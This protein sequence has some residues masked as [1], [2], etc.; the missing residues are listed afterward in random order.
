MTTRYNTDYPLESLPD[1]WQRHVVRLR[2]ESAR[3]RRERTEARAALVSVIAERD[4]AR[5]A[6]ADAQV[7]IASL[8]MDLADLRQ[9]IVPEAAPADV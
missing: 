3:H 8:M 7:Q 5:D 2:A 6:L 4:A 9:G 1:S